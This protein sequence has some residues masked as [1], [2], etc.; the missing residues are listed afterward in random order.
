MQLTTEHISQFQ[1]LYKEQ[2]GEDISKEE[3]QEQALKLLRLV[4]LIYKPM[5]KQEFLNTRNAIEI[6]QKQ[7][8]KKSRLW[9]NS[10][11]DPI[12]FVPDV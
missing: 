1:V 6:I 3:A 2:F 11:V 9:Y 8:N 7:V 12:A 4:Q 10:N 5:T